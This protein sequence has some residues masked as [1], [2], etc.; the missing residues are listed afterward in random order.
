MAF[1]CVAAD[2]EAGKKC[3]EF[4]CGNRFMAR[5]LCD[6][7]WKRA[8]RAGSLME[9]A[10]E[11]KRLAPERCA[12]PECDGDPKWRSDGRGL[13]DKHYD[14][15][16]ASERRQRRKLDLPLCTHQG[17]ARKV[18]FGRT[19]FCRGH[20]HHFM[21]SG[22]VGIPENAGERLKQ[23]RYLWRKEHVGHPICNSRGMTSVHRLVLFNAIGPGAHPCHWCGIEVEW[24]RGNYLGSLVVDHLDENR[25]NNRLENL[26]PSCTNCNSSRTGFQKWIERNLLHPHTEGVL[27]QALEKIR[28]SRS[29]KDAV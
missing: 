4:G 11:P 22:E 20:L 26:V 13:C 3:S 19:D 21:K 16:R 23:G 5:G 24:R 8:K 12:S 28:A 14:K 18:Q 6:K 2:A 27:T 29:S 7:H 10:S 25:L 1:E 17:C 15:A 9:H